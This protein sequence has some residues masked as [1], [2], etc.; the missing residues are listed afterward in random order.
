MGRRILII[1]LGALGD[2]VRTTCLLPTLKRAYPTSQITWVTRVSGAR[3]LA[4]HPLI[5]RVMVMNAEN[6]LVLGGQKFDLVLSLDKEAEPAALG[7]AVKCADKRGMILSEWGTVKPCNAECEVYFE[8]GLDDE[9]KFNRNEKSYPEL[10]HE[11]VGLAYEREPYRLYCD[12]S[13][14]SRAR[15]MFAPWRSEIRGPIVG[16][17]TGS[18]TVFANKAPRPIWWVELARRLMAKRYGVVLLGGPEESKINAWILE[19]VGDGIF[20][21][22]CENTEQEFLAVIDQCDAVVTGDTLAL[23]LAVAREV[24]VVGLFGPTCSQEID[25]FD[26][27][28]KIVSSHGCGPCYRRHCEKKPS[29]MDVISVGEVMSAV[30]AVCGR[31]VETLLPA[32]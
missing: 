9:I 13:A 6:I 26:L 32:S 20:D 12:D 16:L 29:C 19:Q 10:I 18:G 4:S 7:G 23:H 27:G 1:K 17:N 14:A 11:A 25:L 22:G 21:A 28:R 24:P 31:R 2:V 8:L 3:L 5:D 15:L 30:T